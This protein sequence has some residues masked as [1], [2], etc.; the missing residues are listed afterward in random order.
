MKITPESIYDFKSVGAPSFSPDGSRL[1]FSVGSCSREK[2]GYVCDVWEL[3]NGGPRQLTFSGD[4]FGFVWTSENT[5]L[6]PALREE[7]YISRAASGEALTCYYELDPAGGEASLAFTLPFRASG[8]Q[9]VG[10][11]RYVFSARIELE[12][13]PEGYDVFDEVP[14]WRNGLYIINKKRDVLYL[15]D[16][17]KDECVR[18]SDPER[19]AYFQCVS[20]GL[21]CYTGGPV[22]DDR[23]HLSGVYLYDT[24]TGE[25]R[26]VLDWAENVAVSA[27]RFMKDDLVLIAAYDSP[28]YTGDNSRF[29][30]WDHVTGRIRLFNN[31]EFMKEA[32]GAATDV[33]QT[34]G[35]RSKSTPE[36]LYFFSYIVDRPALKL[37]RPDGVIE[38]VVSPENRYFTGFDLS[39]GKLVTAAFTETAPAELYV[40][41]E[42]ATF[43]NDRVM[44]GLEVSVPEPV[45]FT[46]S[47]GYRISGWVMKPCGY[48]PGKK[49]PGILNMHGGPRGASNAVFDHSEQVYAAAGYFVFFCNHRGSDGRGDAFANV[50]GL[51]GDVDYKNLM[52]FTDFVLDSYPDIDRDRL[53]VAGGSYGGFMCNWIIGHT[54]RF[55]AACSQRSVSNWITFEHTCDIGPGYTNGYFAANTA[56]N[57]EYLWDRSPLKYAPNVVTPT[58]FIYSDRDVDCWMPETVQMFTA[59]QMKGVESKVC[60]FHGENHGLSRSGKPENRISR[61]REIVGWFD[62]YLK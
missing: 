14:F 37:L 23:V 12:P 39:G 57:A 38:D 21:I 53:G 55:K 13:Q 32:G 54:D 35:R 26:T 11:D 19:H 30:L 5:I 6:F 59:L 44:S 43:F 20:D 33:N 3:T 48:E 49:Y 7:P 51:M 18:I 41:G 40:N 17:A 46:A 50:R 42:R 34:P 47:D 15:Y 28:M 25:T 31:Y 22:R 10:K 62:K 61:L 58:L 9:C 1:C 27:V 8:L 60:V 45:Y 24:A 2:N 56:E 4:A 52:E 29:Y 16:R 36:G